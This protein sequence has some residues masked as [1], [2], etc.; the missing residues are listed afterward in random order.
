MNKKGQSDAMEFLMT[1][2]WAI[3]VVLIAVG[4]L[5]YFIKPTYM[6]PEKCILSTGHGLSCDK[7]VSYNSEI[8]LN[9]ESS[10]DEYIIISDAYIKQGKIGKC[11]L[12]QPE[13]IEPFGEVILVF[14]NG[15]TCSDLLD[16]KK[17]VGDIRIKFKDSDN[18]ISVITGD[19][20]VEVIDF[21]I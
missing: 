6:L 17:I 20:I 9:I 10:L 1:Y 14:N 11:S 2:G 8:K 18:F 5:M 16:N 15:D 21:D 19:L 13:V 4:A 12:Y 3:L 7:F